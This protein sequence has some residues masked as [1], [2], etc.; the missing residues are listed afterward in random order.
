MYRYEVPIDDEP[1]VIALSHSP[2]AAAA[3]PAAF[4]VEF[5]AEHTDGAT[6]VER[7]FQIFGTGHP[8]PEGARWVATCQR[9]EGFIWHLYEIGS[10]HPRETT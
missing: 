10:G 9:V 2:I 5:W 6:Q 3:Q 1:H 7:T 8:L 4:I